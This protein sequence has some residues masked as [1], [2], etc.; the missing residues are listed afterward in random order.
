MDVKKLL[1]ITGTLDC[2]G[3]ETFLMKIFRRL[4]RTKYIM[5]FCIT[6]PEKCYY[7]DEVEL[8][9]GKIYRIPQKSQSLSNFKKRLYNVVKGGNYRYVLRVTSTPLGFLDAKIAKK[10]GAEICS[11]RSSNSSEGGGF[12]EKIETFVGRALYG[13]YID[14]KI[15][16]SDLAARH[17]FGERAYGNGD[18]NI[19]HN[20]I[21][22]ETYRFDP[23]AR[24]RLRKDFGI[25]DTEILIGHIGRFAK[26][27]NHGFLIEVFAESLRRNPACRLILIGSGVLENKIKE[28]ASELGVLDR[29]IFTGV[30]SDIPD[31]L[32]AIDVFAFPS[33][34]EGMP[35]TV[36]EAQATG[37]HCIIS[38]TIT[39]EADITGLV[40][41]LPIDRDAI[42][43]WVDSVLESKTAERRSQKE[44]FIRNHYDI[45]SVVND[46]T[47]LVFGEKTGNLT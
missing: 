34:F 25:A 7:D 9:G 28:K 14:V 36:I 12:R 39:R 3:A 19:L 30:R 43:V 24:A 11:V 10:A 4:D 22:S 5:D 38:D 41:Y 18:V 46:F 37:L 23:A 13:K 33:L 44:A 47:D 20:A 35:N 6:V 26:Q 32:S 42:G 15:A 31:L 21:D 17:T 8:L 16:P 2:G 40:R 27:K 45:D 1:C 29:I